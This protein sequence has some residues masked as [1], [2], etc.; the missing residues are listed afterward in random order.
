[1]ALLAHS[2]ELRKDLPMN[3]HAA[4][5]IVLM[6]LTGATPSFAQTAMPTHHAAPYPPGPAAALLTEHV[7]SVKWT[8]TTLEEVVDWLRDAADHRVNIMPRWESLATEGIGPDARITLQLENTTVADVL[9]EALRQLAPVGSLTYQA[10]RNYLR[11]S[12]RRDFDAQRYL[13]VYDASDLV[14]PVAD[15]GEDA[16]QIDLQQSG[17]AGGTGGTS[18]F[19]GRGTSSGGAESEQASRDDL[20]RLR[21]AIVATIA[22]DSWGAP[23]GTGPGR[24]AVF[25]RSLLVYQTAE[26]HEQIAGVFV[27]GE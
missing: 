26:V 12:T 10:E 23:F 1:L 19:S 22:P 9:S 3:R 20:A 8:D 27:R 25:R 6:A 7:D 5:G 2:S 11:L 13:R 18:V 24:I 4:V 21:D 17:S 15:F 16:P 14:F